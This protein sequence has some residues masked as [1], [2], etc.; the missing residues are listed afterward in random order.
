MERF[1]A[2]STIEVNGKRY[3]LYRI[4][5]LEEEGITDISSLPFSIRV[6]LEN[7]LR[8]LDGRTVTEDDVRKVAG[9]SGRYRRPVEIAY[10]PARVILQD[11]TGV[12]CI[13][14]LAAMRD[15]MVELGRDPE[16]INP[17]VPVDLVIDHSIQVDHYGSSDAMSKNMALEYQRNRERYTLL[18][19]AQGA[20]KNLRVFP[21][22]TGIIH[23]V[24]LEYIARVVTTKEGSEGGLALPDTVIGTDSHTTMING[25]GILG[26][27]VGGIEAEAVMLGQP[28]Y[29]PIPE[30]VGVRLTGEL[31]EGVTAT[32][33]VLTITEI[34][35]K[36]GVVGKFVEFFGPGV[37]SM[38]IPDRATLANMAPEYGA[39]TGFFPVDE[40]TIRY[41]RLTNRHD[42][43]R[44]V[45]RYTK[46]QGLFYHGDEEPRYSDVIELDM[47][48]IVPSLAGPSRPQHRIPVGDM[49]E[50]FH[51]FAGI[52]KG[53][54]KSVKVTLDGEEVELTDGS[55]VIAAITSCTNTSNPSVML[56]AGLLAKKAVEKGLKPR[57][58]VK[59]SL[60]PGSRVVQGYLEKAGL[61]SYLEALG[62][63][64]VGFGC[65]TCIG[66]SGPLHPEVDR[67]ITEKGLVVSAVLSGNRNF[68]ARIHQRVRANY[69]ASPPLVVAYALA[70]RVDIDLSREPL[71]HDREGREVYLKDLWPSLREIQEIMH[72]VLT[73]EIYADRYRDILKG[74]REWQELH[75][76]S[77][78]TFKWDEGSTYIKKPPF[79]REFRLEPGSLQ[80]IERARVLMLLGD[81]VT[82]D[83]ISPAGSIPEDYPAGRYLINQ[84]VRPGDFNTYGSRRGNHEVMIRGTFANVRI[85][86]RLVSREGGYTLKLP[87][88][89]ELFVYEAARRYMEE[90]VPLIVLA[91]R[92]Y[93]TGSSRDWAAKGTRLLGIR[94]VIA[95]SF[96]RIH[97]SNLVGMGILPLLFRDGDGWET[98][99][100]DG[101]EEFYIQGIKDIHPHKILKVRTVK[102]NG[103]VKEF[104]VIAGLDTE[105][106]VEYLRHGGILPFVLRM[107]A[108]A[109]PGL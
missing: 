5:R 49:K 31:P 48:T 34:L 23:Q 99:G 88:R 25:L 79:F 55:V 32:D 20:F 97:R 12:P 92:E 58:F 73:P 91:G 14:D 56:G 60:A 41:L 18:K 26:W 63:H 89:E 38:S 62:F 28:Y 22:G 102:E 15:V 44:L 72:S 36:Y 66:N 68:E 13:V 101:T 17:L 65:S 85:K 106:E 59:T 90:G 54:K 94:A 70:G 67:V 53:Y 75:C 16:R 29:M 82:T 21:P 11:F 80:D 61:L 77:G 84:R 47:S 27:G 87:E 95:G 105:M 4:K 93:G 2:E 52:R 33:L 8:N 9:W 107:M 83:H 74:D 37:K 39:T 100:L 69:L 57:P 78:E 24:N 30:V 1:G 103:E 96:E 40:E 42:V 10:Y 104:D 76:L 98:L 81:T 19:W 45:E 51:H 35:R 3:T 71:G 50:R 7:L 108:H 6:L 64:T 46:E 109:R 43:A 86:N